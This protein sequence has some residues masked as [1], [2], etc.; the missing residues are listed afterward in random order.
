MEGNMQFVP[1]V[2][3]ILVGLW[4]ALLARRTARNWVLWMVGGAAFTLVVSTIVVGLNHAVLLPISH[5]ASTWYC[6]RTIVQA[7]VLVFALGW[8]F[9]MGLHGQHI[10]L[11]SKLR[12]LFG[13]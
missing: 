12:G 9:T 7:T 3:C 8:L 11:V 6:I 4:F 5:E 10:P 1:W 2:L 13:K